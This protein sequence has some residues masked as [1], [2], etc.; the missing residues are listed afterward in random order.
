MPEELAPALGEL[1]GFLI[2]SSRCTAAA[3]TTDFDLGVDV[4]PQGSR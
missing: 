2:D 3:A 4:V 1:F